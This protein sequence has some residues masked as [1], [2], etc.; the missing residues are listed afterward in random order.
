MANNPA[1]TNRICIL[2]EPVANE[3]SK[4]DPTAPK[5]LRLT[6]RGITLST[7]ESKR[8]GKNSFIQKPDHQGGPT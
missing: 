8:I 7:R 6:D 2:S 5:P 1:L 4:D 3:E